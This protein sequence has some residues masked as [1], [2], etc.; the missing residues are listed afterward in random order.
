MSFLWRKNFV[1]LLVILILL[2]GLAGYFYWEDHQYD[3]FLQVIFLDIGQ[4]DSILIKTSQG[5]NIL[6][7]GGPDNSVI[8]QISKF[9]PFFS[10]KIDLIILTHPDSDHLTGLIEILKRFLVKEI[11]ENGTESPEPE[12]LA[13]KDLISQKDIDYKIIQQGEILKIQPNLILEILLPNQNLLAEKKDLNTTSI[14]AKLTFDQIDFLLTGDADF[15]AEKEM[16]NQKLDISVE[17]LKIAHHGSKYSS[18]LEF[19][20]AVNP[21]L[22]IIPVGENKFGHP[23]RRVL[24]NLQNLEISVLTTQNEGNIRIFSDG[25]KWWRK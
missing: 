11:W 21:E 2:A 7:D 9:L 23:S 10:K 6:I 5:K 12:F 17:I 18:S 25:E 13:W 15:I 4:G 24:K 19:L 20:E 14:V 1:L 3:N 8:Y 16:I 22:A